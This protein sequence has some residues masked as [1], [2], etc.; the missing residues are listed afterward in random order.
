ML[1]IHIGTDGLVSSADIVQSADPD[2]E[3]AAVRVA[4]L[5]RFTPAYVGSQPVAVKM[6]QAIQFKLQR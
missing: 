5:L 1:D 2:F 6:R 3:Q 4:E